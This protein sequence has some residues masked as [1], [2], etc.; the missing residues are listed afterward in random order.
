MAECREPKKAIY[1]LLKDCGISGELEIDEEN[2]KENIEP[3]EVPE[4][5]YTRGRKEVNNYVEYQ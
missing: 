2:D 3:V 4:E 1:H 5:A